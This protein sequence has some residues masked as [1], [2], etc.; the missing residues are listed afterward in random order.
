M[1]RNVWILDSVIERVMAGRGGFEVFERIEAA[2]TG[3]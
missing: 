2:E 1:P 3:P